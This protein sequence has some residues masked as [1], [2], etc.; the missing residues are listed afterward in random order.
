MT[1]M[2]TN[3]GPL[4]QLADVIWA[5]GSIVGSSFA[6]TLVHGLERNSTNI[7]ENISVET[8][9]ENMILLLTIPGL[10]QFFG[11]TLLWLGKKLKLNFNFLVPVF[12]FGLYWTK[13]RYVKKKS[14]EI[15]V[16]KENAKQNWLK[17]SLIMAMFAF[18]VSAM[19]AYDSLMSTAWQ[20]LNLELNAKQA[21]LVYT[22]YQVAQIVPGLLNAILLTKINPNIVIGI[23][24]AITI[25]SLVLLYFFRKV[26]IAIYILN[27]SYG[28]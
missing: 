19:V 24:L 28:K 23:H 1:E 25:A 20:Y 11:K 9:R 15:I 5:V 21:S 22:L 18:S 2:W 16:A 12:L 14:E 4:L 13:Y 6:S 7:T 26:V 10:L 17:M 27:I 3:A 8:R